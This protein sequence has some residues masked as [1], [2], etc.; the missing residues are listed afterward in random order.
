MELACY[1]LF[2]VRLV[3]TEE[4]ARGK[5]T[6][7][8]VEAVRDLLESTWSATRH[9]THADVA[10]FRSV[11][12]QLR[13]VFEA[14]ATGNET[15]AVNLLNPLLLEFP[16]STQ[17]TGHDH[18]DEHD[19]PLW[20][21]RLAE[22]PSKAT[23]GYAAIGLAFY[24]TEFGVDRLGVCKAAPCRNAYL[25]NSINRSRRYC[26][27]RCASRANVGLHRARKRLEGLHADRAQREPPTTP[28]PGTPAGDTRTGG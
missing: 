2:A 23:V 5:D 3:N 21:M 15:D 27:D 11:R 17:I 4:P 18:R 28:T 16:V 12:G 19:R 22:H 10:R 8:S 24:L 7:T 14:A 13:A 9:I 25:D 1:S 20:Q 6:L 26:S